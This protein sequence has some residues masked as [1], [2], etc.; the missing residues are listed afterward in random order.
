MLEFSF[1]TA[2]DV[3]FGRGVSRNAASVLADRFAKVL[4]LHGSRPGSVAWLSS[5]LE[6]HAV[7]V[8]TA[9]GGGEPTVEGV[10]ATIELARSAGVQAVVAVGGGSVLDL[11]KAVAGLALGEQPVEAYLG[12][13]GAP[14]P[15]PNQNLFF[16]AI[17]TT[18]GTGA[19]VTKNAVLSV[20]SLG[21]KVSLRGP[22]LLPDLALVDPAL[23]DNSPLP[24]T[25]GSG[26]DAVTQVIEAYVSCKASP[27]TDSLCRAALPGG[28]R[29]LHTLAQAE[30]AEARDELAYASLIGGLALA[31]AGLGAVHGLAGVI[32]GMTGSPHGQI[33]AAL[34]PHVLSANTHM[35]D[36]AS[37]SHQKL[38]FVQKAVADV[39]DTEAQSSCAALNA[40][41][42]H[43]GMPSLGDLGVKEADIEA[44]SE[45]ALGASSTRGN[46]VAFD[47]GAFCG[48][49]EAALA[50]AN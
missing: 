39:L 36:T 6:E 44:I 34:L 24:V 49:L 38:L 28:L 45:M 11:G 8:T 2:G 43:N 19:E 33:C 46:P 41:M 27:L 5:L 26:M 18:A 37:A 48:V 50:D 35:A 12:V 32:G 20:T 7:D 22:Q 13:D 47:K 30:T 42:R 1:Q 15:L 9:A 16:V 14:E 40:W 23:T 10:A 3:R 21:Q 4:L 25:M 17:P 31:N 29:A